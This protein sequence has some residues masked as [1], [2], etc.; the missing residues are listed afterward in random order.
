MPPSPWI[1][2]AMN[3]AAMLEI[4]QEIDR[5]ESEADKVMRDAVS[6]LFRDERDVRQLIKL[7]AGQTYACDFPFENP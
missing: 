3:A 2:S 4:C 7:K 6:K 1:G 5:L